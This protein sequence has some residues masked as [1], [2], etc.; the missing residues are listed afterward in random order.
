MLEMSRNKFV[1]TLTTTEPKTIDAFASAQEAKR[2]EVA[3]R[4]E[5]QSNKS[6]KNIQ[7]CIDKVLKEL[8]QRILGEITLDE[9]RKKDHPQPKT[10][11]VSMKRKETDNSYDK[12]GFPAG[13]T[14]AHR[15][16]LRKECSR[17]L[18]FAYLADF[19]SL[20][21]LSQIYIYSLESMIDRIRDLDETTN[22]DVIMTMV[23]DDAN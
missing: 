18:R 10:N 8:R 19:L 13:M 1:D 12:L 9:Q 3:K 5:A 6:R 14:Y 23:F 16:S 21:A 22:M 17:F 4:I 20:E 15:S 2:N 11:S 7:E